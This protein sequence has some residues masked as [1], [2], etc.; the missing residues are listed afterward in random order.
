MQL[1][2]SDYSAAVLPQRLRAGV[3][4][5]DERA[6]FRFAVLMYVLFSLLDCMT[7][8]VA[9]ATGG[10]RERN[11][12]AA[13]LYRGYGAGGLYV[14]KAVVVAIIVAGLMRVPR[15]LAIWVAT[16]FAAA[17]ALAVYGNLHV[18]AH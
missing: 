2:Q 7:S 17:V 14:F 10:A 3:S 18:I 8:V 6:V 16:A 15:R 9:L 5:N 13:S 4:P 1:L 11:P 12:L